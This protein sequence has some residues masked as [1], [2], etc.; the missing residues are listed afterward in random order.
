M[1]FNN[2]SKSKALTS[3]IYNQLKKLTDREPAFPC[4]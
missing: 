3:Y 1:D 2:V 4:M